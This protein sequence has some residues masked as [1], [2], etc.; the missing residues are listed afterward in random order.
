MS[1]S[2]SSKKGN[3][4]NDNSNNKNDNKTSLP[5]NVTK[6]TSSSSSFST[7]WRW[8]YN[9]ATQTD[10]VNLWLAF[11]ALVG[12]SI[13]NLTVPRILQEVVD[14]TAA[15][16]GVLNSRTARRVEFHTFLTGCVG[17]F[18]CGAAASFFRVYFLNIVKTTIAN[19]LRQRIVRNVISKDM[20]YYDTQK[21][22]S[23]E[24]IIHLSNDVEKLAEVV[25]DK[26]AKF[27]RGLNST[28]GGTIMLLYISPKLTLATV[29]VVPFVG[30]VAMLFS[31]KAKRLA[32]KLKADVNQANTRI[33][34][35]IANIKTV[36]LAGRDK[37]EIETYEKA[38]EATMAQTKENAIADGTFMGG[39]AFAINASLLGVMY[40]GGNLLSTGELSVG[41]LTSFAIYS[42]L[43]GAGS[44]NLASIYS[45]MKQSM[46][47][48]DGIFRLLSLPQSNDD[49]NTALLDD[50]TTNYTDDIDTSSICGPI[51]FRNVS[52]AYPNRQD[53]PILK[54]VSFTIK[55]GKVLAIIGTSGAGK[56]TIAMLMCGI[57]KVDSGN[58]FY[59]GTNINTLN[60][61]ALRLSIGI[62][63]QEPTLFAMSIKDNIKYGATDDNITDKDIMNAAKEANAH[64]FICNL[65]NGYDT[66]IQNTTLS[67]GQKQRIAIARA[68]VNNP[69]I[70]ILD[71]ATSALD[72]ASEKI[73]VETLERVSQSRTVLVIAHR[74]SSYAWADTILQMKGKNGDGFTLS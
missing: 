26:S 48:S 11:T 73:V 51:E 3:K 45:S 36:R 22:V 17:F 67:G 21:N 8:V 46:G 2:S 13:T 4:I 71:E 30:A 42:G 40:M 70:L 32:K 55:K 33:Q 57:Y 64:D 41:S 52:F 27:L 1:S 18:V 74:N 47:M 28:I 60:L 7:L 23:A 62:V 39:L 43:V 34:E 54:D 37:Y 63:N 69:S 44:A 15:S 38:M 31:R 19:R 25:T 9:D 49:A 68:V 50:T 20:T 12:S 29:S 5:V 16:G 59:N 65:P 10:R 66:Q 61:N 14:R 72:P 6:R 53:V 58:I 35:R 56:S 24:T